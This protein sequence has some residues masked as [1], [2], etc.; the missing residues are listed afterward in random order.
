VA[1]PSRLEA[2]DTLEEGHRAVSALLERLT[3]ERTV[4]PGT[5]GGGG[6]SAKDLLGH[7][8]SWEGH[9]LRAVREW[10]RGERPWVED[11]FRSPNEVD[12][13][14]AEAAAATRAMPLEEVRGTAE[15][16]HRALIETIAS[17]T[18]EEWN[19][20]A[21]YPTERRSRLGNL[22]GSVTGAPGRPFGHA[23]AHLED[24]RAYV[25]RATSSR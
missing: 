6:W 18:D 3:D 10:R 23:W 21:P 2:I 1:Q 8:A 20:K 12:R 17:M 16:T 4:A 13:V 22:L 25:D 14:N 24:L 7:L 11:V 15:R 19:A 9:G 5:I